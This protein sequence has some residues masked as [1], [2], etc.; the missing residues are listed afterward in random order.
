[1][2]R[3]MLPEEGNELDSEEAAEE[4]A[5]AGKSRSRCGLADRRFFNAAA[6]P[7]DIIRCL[8]WIKFFSMATAP[9]SHSACWSVRSWELRFHK[10]PHA[11]LTM[12][13]EG[14]RSSWSSTEKAL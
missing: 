6:E 14:D 1:M 13:R 8:E 10:V 11:L 2:C 12:V 3:P 5:E 7:I 9:S 4:K